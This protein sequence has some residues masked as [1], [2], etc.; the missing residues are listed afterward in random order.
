[1]GSKPEEEKKH[2]EERKMFECAS[3]GITK[4]ELP[5]EPEMKTEASAWNA[6]AYHWEEK[7]VSEWA[8]NRLKELIKVCHLENE[9]KKIYISDIKNF[10][11]DVHVHSKVF[12]RQ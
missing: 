3:K 4:T 12:S 5:K 10:N 7:A 8:T 9:G 1:L 2:E 6:N 11:G